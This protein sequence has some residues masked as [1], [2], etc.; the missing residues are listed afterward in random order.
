MTKKAKFSVVVAVYNRPE[1][2]SELLESIF[3]QEYRDFEIII[4]DDGSQRSSR[5]IFQE[6]RD[7]LNISYFFTEN[8]GPALA[9][10]FGV[11]KSE[12]EWVIFFDSDCTIPQNYFFEVEKYLNKNKID[13]YGGPD[14]MDDSFTY[15]QKSINYSMTSLLT[16]GGI[17]GSKSSIDKFIPRSFNMGIKRVA[18]DEVGGFSD[19][20]QYGEDLDLSYKLIFSGKKSALIPDA[21]VYHKRRTNLLNFFRQ[22]I[23]SGKGRHYLNLKY[24]GT[25]RLFHLF[26]TL[27]ILGF[28][29]SQILYVFYGD[30]AAE[31]IQIF[32]GIYFGAIFLGSSAINR[33]PIIGFL[34]VITTFTQFLGYGM[35]YVY[36]L[37]RHKTK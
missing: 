7:K 22:M 33:N 14:I 23:K 6:Y 27:F 31:I 24:G 1:E 13:F 3:S 16:T 12:G 32:Y 28:I 30:K 37:V 11:S 34:S 35:G 5:E 20:R 18:F 29:I 17:R 15:L 8:Q 2:M 36:G 4:V 9:R 10:N 21:K 25:F 19:I 26:P